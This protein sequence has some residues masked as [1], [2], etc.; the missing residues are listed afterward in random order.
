[1]NK[2]KLSPLF[3]QI[4]RLVSIKLMYPLTTYHLKLRTKDIAL[5]KQRRGC[6]YHVRLP[7]FHCLK[8]GII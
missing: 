1:M 8:L 4:K 5:L 7:I 3:F 6:I 2:S